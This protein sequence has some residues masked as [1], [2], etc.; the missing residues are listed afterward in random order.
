VRVR[1]IVDKAVMGRTQQDQ[2]AKAVA[3]GFGL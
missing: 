1:W 3:V 2:V